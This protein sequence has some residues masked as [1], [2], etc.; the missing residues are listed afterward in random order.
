VIAANNATKYG[1]ALD[2]YQLN[3]LD[4]AM[5]KDELDAGLL[6]AGSSIAGAGISAGGSIAGGLA[7]RI[8]EATFGV[9]HPATNRARYRVNVKWPAWAKALY[10]RH[11]DKAAAFIKR[12]P[13]SKLI[14]KPVFFLIGLGAPEMLPTGEVQ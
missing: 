8:A 1:T 12:H 6:S 4:P 14:A 10:M 7:C 13:A 11:M 9:D 5:R 2:E 3:E